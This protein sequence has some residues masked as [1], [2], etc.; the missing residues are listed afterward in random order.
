MFAGGFDEN[1]L[2]LYAN[3]EQLD[4]VG[5]P[6]PDLTLGLSNSVT[7]GRFDFSAFLEGAFGHQ[8][9]NNTANAIF[10]KGNLRNGRNVTQEIADDIASLRA[11]VDARQNLEAIRE[12]MSHLEASA[13]R[14]AEMLYTNDPSS[15]SNAD[16]GGTAG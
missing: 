7:F 15:S 4:F 12:Q 10:L 1:G 3:N 8:V 6:I 9:Y 11:L 14:I 2:G 16:E 13:Y 5:S